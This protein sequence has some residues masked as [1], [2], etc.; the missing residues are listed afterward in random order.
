M[1]KEK[2]SMID[3]QKQQKRMQQF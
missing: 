3:P 1:K 2:V